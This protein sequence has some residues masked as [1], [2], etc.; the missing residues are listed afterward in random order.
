MSQLYNISE[1]ITKRI[2]FC[3]A[4]L[5]KSKY[6]TL[7][8]H[9]DSL[10]NNEDKLA[11]FAQLISKMFDV[12]IDWLL[13]NTGEFY[14]ESTQEKLFEISQTNE[15]LRLL[16]I[17]LLGFE[18]DLYS[19][20]LKIPDGAKSLWLA[21]KTINT[22]TLL[23]SMQPEN[24][25][26]AWLYVLRHIKVSSARVAFKLGKLDEVQHIYMAYKHNDKALS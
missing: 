20:S 4:N 21:N 6:K 3:L 24:D 13:A 18:V 1:G 5:D 12:S 19:T 10:K 9:L 14:T 26:H 2:E 15:D 23:K 17:N 22:E 11:I 8:Q 25:S 16:I 7:L